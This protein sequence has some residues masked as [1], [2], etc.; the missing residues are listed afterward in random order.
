MDTS[1]FNNKRYSKS[2]ESEINTFT[3]HRIEKLVNLITPCD[4]L[5]DLGCWDGFIMERIIEKHKAKKVIGVD[6]AISAV[7]RGRKRGLDIRL[8]KSV[9][10]ELP[11]EDGTFN[12]VIAGEIIEH[13]YD[14]NS[15]IKEIH[16][17]LKPGGQLIITTPN[18]ASLGSRLTLLLGK[19]PWMIENELGETSAGH[20]RY[21]TF[22]SL[23]QLLE[24]YNFKVVNET[25]EAVHIGTKVIITNELIT[26]LGHKWGRG[27]IAKFIKI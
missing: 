5:L 20:M 22:D 25:V 23:R 19:T 18:L 26:K 15:F 16:R 13:L 12:C 1:K 21:F 6:N 4:N 24:K 7:E 9:D 10:E 2:L 14:V 11:F 17:V 3:H 27:I 8:I